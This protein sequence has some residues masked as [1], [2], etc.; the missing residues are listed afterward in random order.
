MVG[1]PGFE[2]GPLLRDGALPLSY[3]CMEQ[4]GGFEPPL[5]VLVQ[6]LYEHPDKQ[7]LGAKVEFCSFC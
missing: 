5:P 6:G 1:N 3:I 2:P 7:I 4:T